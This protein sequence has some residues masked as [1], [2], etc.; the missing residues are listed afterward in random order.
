MAIPSGRGC[1]TDMKPCNALASPAC[2]N[3]AGTFLPWGLAFQLIKQ[4]PC[5]PAR[6]WSVHRSW[7][8][9]VSRRETHYR[10][11]KGELQSLPCSFPA[12]PSF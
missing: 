8:M 11:C 2:M 5:L 6:Q 1:D 9:L 3:P 7:L 10:V 4:S 12:S